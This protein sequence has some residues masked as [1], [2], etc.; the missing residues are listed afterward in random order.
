[1][2][3]VDFKEH[4]GAARDK[5]IRQRANIPGSEKST[6]S[7]LNKKTSWNQKK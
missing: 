5:G 3:D 1:M 7:N 2:L 4:I 6:S